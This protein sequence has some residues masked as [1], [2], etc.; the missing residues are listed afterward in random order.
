[1]KISDLP[2]KTC[3]SLLFS[4]L[5]N[6]DVKFCNIGVRK[7]YIAILVFLVKIQINYVLMLG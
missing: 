3:S 5:K 4:K 7:K 1:M 2:V 6:Y